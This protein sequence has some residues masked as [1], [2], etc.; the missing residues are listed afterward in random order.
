M[1]KDKCVWKIWGRI[2][3]GTPQPVWSPECSNVNFK[4]ELLINSFNFCPYCGK[5]IEVKDKE[6]E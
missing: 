2:L 1:N 6:V 3:V 5:P 4:D